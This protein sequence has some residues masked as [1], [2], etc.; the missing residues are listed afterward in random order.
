[1][2]NYTHT[3]THNLYVSVNNFWTRGFKPHDLHE[4][5]SIKVWPTVLDT[6]DTDAR[7]GHQYLLSA[8]GQVFMYAF[9]LNTLRMRKVK[10]KKGK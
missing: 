3:H 6:T 1:M 2:T 4:N 8:L 9:S 7:R 10:F 5:S